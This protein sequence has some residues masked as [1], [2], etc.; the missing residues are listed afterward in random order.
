M[1]KV[2]L[3]AAATVAATSVA[4]AMVAAARVAEVREAEAKE[5]AVWVAAVTAEGVG[6]GVGLAKAVQVV[7]TMAAAT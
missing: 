3:E 2:G 5:V 6:E 7:D 4:A 1:A